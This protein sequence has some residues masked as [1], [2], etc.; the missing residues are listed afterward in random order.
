ADF[1]L[2]GVD[3]EKTLPGGGSLQLAW[4]TSQG[5]VP[6]TGNIFGATTDSRHDGN[7]YQVTLVE[8][9]PFAGATLRGRFQAASAGFFNPFGGTV[10]PGSRRG[11]V[12][13]EMKP[14]KNS[15]LRFGVTSER[16]QTANVDNRRLT[17]SAAW[18]QIMNDRIRFHLG[19]DHRGF[20]D[21]L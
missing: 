6:G 17:F 10:T 21:D 20:T 5:E 4:A 14:L 8:P 15:M 18:D 1:A 2:G 3:I 7:A 12:T 16:N 9:L 11:E 19:F 13:L